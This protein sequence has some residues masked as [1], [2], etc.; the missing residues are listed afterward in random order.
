[1]SMQDEVEAQSNPEVKE[2]VKESIVPPAVIEA[3]ELSKRKVP[4][5]FI[6]TTPMTWYERLKVRL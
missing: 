5:A 4:E 2:P 3:K 1:M 6:E